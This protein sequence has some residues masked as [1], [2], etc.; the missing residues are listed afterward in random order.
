MSGRQSVGGDTSNYA[1]TR[2][3]AEYSEASQLHSQNHNSLHLSAAF[4]L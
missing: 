4:C 1:A 2:T 3:Q